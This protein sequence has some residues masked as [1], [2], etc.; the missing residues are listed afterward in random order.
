MKVSLLKENPVFLAATA[1]K[2]SRTPI[3]KGS[4]SQILK[5]C[6]DNPEKSKRLVKA[7]L[8]YGHMIPAD[9][10]G[11]AVSLEDISRLAAIYFWRN[12]NAPNLIF[13]AGIEASLRLIKANN[14]REELGDFGGELFKGYEKLLDLG[15]PI[16][17]A[18]YV[19]PEATLTRMIFFTPPRY[20]VK[21]ANSLE[22]T[23]LSELKE[24]GKR[25]KEEVKDYFLEIPKEKESSQ[26]NFW[27]KEEI[28]EE[29]MLDYQSDDIHSLS[30]N[31]G[32]VGSL[33]MYAQLVRQRQ[34]LCNIESLEGIARR[35]TFVVPPTFPKKGEEIYRE[36]AK[37][38]QKKQ[39]ELIKD[40]KASFAYSLLLGQQAKAKIYAK[41]FGIIK[42]SRARSEGVAQWE[43]RSSLG[44]PLT[45]K[46]AENYPA[47]KKDIGPNCWRE[48]KCREPETFKTKEAVCPAFT[49][50]GG[51]KPSNLKKCL[52]VLE[53]NY[54]TF[55]I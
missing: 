39:L 7:V 27:G 33:S 29:T 37:K 16:Q 50:W 23:P 3:E 17:D 35:G 47:L 42:T 21:I 25:I 52:D 43:I 10:G 6:K 45:R 28:S 12:V 1:A 32:I 44:V 54:K 19:L 8:G 4:I 31:M 9:F 14:Y 38:A 18:R 36:L 15:I 34:F 11:F 13:G 30:L 5:E 2:I 55:K 49:K 53:E 20:L 40:K 22:N 26:W 24:I 48:G 46:L 41:G 51:R